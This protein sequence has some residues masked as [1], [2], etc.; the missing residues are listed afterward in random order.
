MIAIDNST[1]I[2]TGTGDTLVSLFALPFD[3]PAEL[4]TIFTLMCSIP[5]GENSLA[6][7]VL[8]VTMVPLLGGCMV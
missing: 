5:L 1:D 2:T 8:D 4:F 3:D 6:P 7:Y